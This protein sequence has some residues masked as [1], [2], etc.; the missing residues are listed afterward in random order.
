MK[1]VALQLAQ[2]IIILWT[3][4]VE[5]GRLFLCHLSISCPYV[6]PYFPVLE[7]DQSEE[8][9]LKTLGYKMQKAGGAEPE[10]SFTERVTACIELYA[11]VMQ[12][13]IET[14]LG[15][16]EIVHPHNLKHAWRWLAEILNGEIAPEMTALILESFL[17]I[18]YR[19]MFIVYGSQFQKIIVMIKFYFI[20]KIEKTTEVTQRATLMKLKSTL[21]EIEKERK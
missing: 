3:Y 10:E 19:E 15:V 4:H 20:P 13:K 14:V 5:F 8:D 9:Y 2:V 7:P 6:I 11:M 17:R 12:C 21:S 18:A 1:N 16:G